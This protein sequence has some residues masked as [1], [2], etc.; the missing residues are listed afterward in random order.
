MRSAA[1]LAH[2]SEQGVSLNPHVSRVGDQFG[3]RRLRSLMGRRLEVLLERLAELG[4]H[5]PF[6]EPRR[7]LLFHQ[8]R[9]PRPALLPDPVRRR[10]ELGQQSTPIH[11]HEV[12]R[13]AFSASKR[14]IPRSNSRIFCTNSCSGVRSVL[15]SSSRR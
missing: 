8:L 14:E 10:F 11:L 12:D 4:A 9:E 6:V 13:S 5:V 15:C 7:R 1:G 3:P 2:L